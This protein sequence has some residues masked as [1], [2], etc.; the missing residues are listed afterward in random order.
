MLI[1]DFWELRDDCIREYLTIRGTQTAECFGEAVKKAEEHLATEYPSQ[2]SNW[3]NIKD[4]P[5]LKSLG[6]RILGY[7]GRKICPRPANV[8][9]VLDIFWKYKL[10]GEKS[11]REQ[12]RF[13]LEEVMLHRQC[14]ILWEL[15]INP[16]ATSASS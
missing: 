3:L 2:W 7:F 15:G 1:R 9:K 11:E 16:D 8:K 4:Y 5:V 13:T 6:A 10:T 14:F 12:E